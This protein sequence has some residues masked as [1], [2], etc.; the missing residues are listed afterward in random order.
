MK[1]RSGS[2]PITLTATSV[3]FVESAVTLG[4]AVDTNFMP[5]RMLSSGCNVFRLPLGPSVSI[6][7]S[8]SCSF[9]RAVTVNRVHCYLLIELTKRYIYKIQSFYC[10]PCSV[11]A[12]T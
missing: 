12:S 3:R 6:A 11:R 7:S 9:C 10:K 5:A 4:G 8:I 1:D 2:R